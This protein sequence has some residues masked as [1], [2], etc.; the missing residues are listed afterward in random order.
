MEKET[1]S[2]WIEAECWAPGEWDINN[3]NTDVVVTFKEDCIK[4]REYYQ[5]KNIP[6]I[7]YSDKDLKDCKKVFDDIANR[8]LL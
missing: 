3:D 4:A 8:Y 1:I 7:V 2:I 6:I 5:E